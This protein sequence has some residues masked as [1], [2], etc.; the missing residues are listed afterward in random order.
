MVDALRALDPDDP[1]TDE[2][3][4]RSSATCS[5]RSSSTPTIAEQEGRFTMADVARG[6]HDKLVRRHPHV[7]GDVVVER[8]R[9]GAAQLGRDQARGEAAHVGVR[10]RPMS[11]PSLSYADAV[12]RKAAKLGFDWPDVDGALPK[13]A[14]EAAELV[15]ATPAAT[16]PRTSPTSSATCCSRSS[17]S[18]ATS[19]ID[20]EAALRAAAHK[21]R[22]RFERSRH[23]PASATSTC[24]PPTWRCST[25]CGT[26][27][28]ARADRV[29]GEAS[30]TPVLAYRSGMSDIVSI[31]GREILDSR[32][33]PTV[34]V[35]VDARLRRHAGAPPS[36]PARRPASTRRSSCATA[37]SASA[38]RACRPRSATSTARSPTRSTGSTRSSSA[39]S[40]T[41]LI[42][43]DGT[44]NKA[45]LGANAILGTSLAVAKAA[46]DELDLPLYRYVGGPNAHV[47]PV[48][49][50]NV[51]QRRRARRQ[52]DRHAGV[53]GDARRRAELPRG[54]ALG[55]RDVPHAQGRAPRPRAWPTAV[56][57]EG[58][59][60]PNLADQ[61]GR[62]Q[63]PRRGDRA[64]RLRARRGHRHRPRPGDERGVPRRR[65]PPRRRGQGALGRRHGRLLGPARR[66][67]SDRQHRGR[68]GRGRLGRLGAR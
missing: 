5:T 17:T 12:Q 15:E 3:S 28:S 7:F 32:G 49:M 25:R 68:H 39:S 2:R 67:V 46:A 48:P 60:A 66:H 31:V 16:M 24:T 42:A 36:R 65:L 18:P 63:D 44:D 23:S 55:H 26:R 22:R 29:V 57:D 58:G 4:S 14:E 43:L 38:A 56:G 34:E 13:I 8:H 19:T 11:L 52:H 41:E 1:A 45:R 50:M 35:E 30:R 6:V 62:D 61:R 54:A 47:L 40:T 37:A 51:R 9:H 21:F 33:N 64:G 27:S 53:H 10:R 59:F 20:P